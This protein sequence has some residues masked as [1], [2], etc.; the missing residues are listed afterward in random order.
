MEW[1]SWGDDQQLEGLR[2]AARKWISATKILKSLLL[3]GNISAFSRGAQN[4]VS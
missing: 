1:A 2:E 3:F 4:L